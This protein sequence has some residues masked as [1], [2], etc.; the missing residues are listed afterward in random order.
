M[1]VRRKYFFRV[2]Q[3]QRLVVP[4]EVLY[5]L[6]KIVT[7]KYYCCN[8]CSCCSISSIFPF[9][10]F[11]LLLAQKATLYAHKPFN[12]LSHTQRGRHAGKRNAISCLETL[13]TYQICLV[14]ATWRLNRV[15]RDVFVCL[16]H[17]WNLPLFNFGHGDCAWRGKKQKVFR[18]QNCCSYNG[19]VLINEQNRCWFTVHN[20]M[21]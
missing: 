5:S 20:I 21:H 14:C 11:S 1:W 7:K 12:G 3:K 9:R 16:A 10:T 13:K 2:K 4:K 19:C 8:S 6:S 18:T 15:W 17:W